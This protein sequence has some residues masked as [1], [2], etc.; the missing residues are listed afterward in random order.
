MEL[1]ESALMATEGKDHNQAKKK[2]KGKMLS[3]GGIKKANS[4]FLYKKKGHMKNMVDVI[5]NT[6]WIDLIL[7]SMFQIPYRVEVEKQCGNQIKIV[8][9]DRGGGYYGRYTKDGQAPGPFV[10][11]KSM[12]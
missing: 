12:G 10:K 8:R 7:E 11:Y 4:C 9:T 6:W 2:G 3:Q 1:G 5:Y